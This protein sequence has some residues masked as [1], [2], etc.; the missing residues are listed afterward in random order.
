MHAILLFLSLLAVTQAGY[1]INAILSSDIKNCHK[2]TDH[3]TCRLFT[4]A[5]I[6]LK[7][8]GYESCIWFQDKQKNN[9]FHM[10]LKFLSSQCSFSSKRK[11]TRSLLST[12][13]FRN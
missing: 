3:Q 13:Q 1:L 11:Y 10:K 7:G 8:L 9:I 12:I 4:T 2:Q 5:E 6:T